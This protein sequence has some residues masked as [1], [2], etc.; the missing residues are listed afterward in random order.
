MGVSN[1]E[2]GGVCVWD[3]E[4]GCSTIYRRGLEKRCS[5]RTTVWCIPLTDTRVYG[6][7]SERGSL[8]EATTSHSALNEGS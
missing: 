2:G 3:A 4:S 1:G 8:S 5:D 6:A 7:A